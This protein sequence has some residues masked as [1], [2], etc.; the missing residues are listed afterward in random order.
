MIIYFSR[1]L[2][3]FLTLPLS[4]KDKGKFKPKFKSVQA[5]KVYVINK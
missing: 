5:K 3:H 2:E 1:A 4:I